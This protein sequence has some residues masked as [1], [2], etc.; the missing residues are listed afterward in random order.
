M[1][2]QQF[3]LEYVINSS[4]KVLYN[5]LS[6]PSG[7]SEWFA[8]DVNVEN[9][10]QTYIFI[11]EKS[12]SKAHVL[13]KKEFVYIRFRLEEDD[14]DDSVFFEFRIVVDELTKDLS[15]IITDFAEPDE[16]V[17]AKQLWNTQIEKL[18]HVLG[19]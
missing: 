12:P 6:T 16:I 19:S 13:A 7:L 3:Q 5:R 15:L 1:D 17:D 14:D 9:N 2:K 18:K 8:D 10:F 4:P 11:W